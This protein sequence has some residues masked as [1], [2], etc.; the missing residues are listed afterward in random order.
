MN[1]QKLIKLCQK[2]NYISFDLYDTLILRNVAQPKDVFELV[3]EKLNIES[4]ANDRIMAEIACREKKAETNIDEIYQELSKKYTEDVCKL[5]QQTELQI[6]S[7]IVCL[8][9]DMY[10]VYQSCVGKHIFI[11]T[12]M[13]LPEDTIKNIL[14]KNGYE[15]YEKLYLSSSYNLTKRSGSLFEQIIMDNKITASQ[16]LHIGDNVLGD[17]LIP[18]FKRI[19]TARIKR[20]KYLSSGTLTQRTLDAFLR[21]ASN[22]SFGYQYLGSLLYG[23]AHWLDTE[24]SKHKYDKI[25]FFSREGSLIKQAYEIIKTTNTDSMYFYA[26]RRALQVPAFVTPPPTHFKIQRHHE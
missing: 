18:I 7:D 2:Y 8:N 14:S 24:F 15:N 4:F 20:Q 13:Y 3:G 1:K 16:L 23:Y 10:D 9:F 11:T 22:K 21:N 17:F 6:E 19:K 25:L 26:S 5:C 12:D